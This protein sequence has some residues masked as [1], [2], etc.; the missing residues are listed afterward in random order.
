MKGGQHVA[1]NIQLLC[2]SCNVRKWAHD[3]IV[4]AQAN[5]RLL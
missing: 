3:P 5:G 2:G 1:Y 4:F